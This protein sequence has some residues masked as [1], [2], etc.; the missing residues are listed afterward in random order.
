[1]I[2]DNKDIFKS[3]TPFAF[4]FL[5]EQLCYVQSYSLSLS[6]RGEASKLKL[7]IP[8]DSIDSSVFANSE[9]EGNK[10]PVELY[11]GYLKDDVHQTISRAKAQELAVAIKQGRSDE[12]KMF[13][14]RF[15]GFASQ[16]EWSFGDERYLDLTCFDW[17]QVLREYKFDKNLKDGDTE[18][19]RIISAIQ[20]KISGIAINSKPYNGLQRMGEKD[21]ESGSYTYRSSGKTYW[22]ILSECAAKLNRRVFV[23]GQEILVDRF[24]N[25]PVLWSMYYGPYEEKVGLKFGQYFKSLKLRYG[26][27]GEASKSNV[28][29]QLYSSVTT[30]KG[31]KSK[32]TAVRYPENAPIKTNTLVIKRN[33]AINTS[34]AELK[35]IAE[36]LFK[37]FSRKN[38]TGNIDIPFANNFLNL[39]DLVTFTA[40]S[41]YTDLQFIK[42]FYFCVNSIDENYDVSGYTQTVDIDTDPDIS[43]KTVTIEDKLAPKPKP[44]ETKRKR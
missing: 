37:K 8:L 19:S 35:V 20:K 15:S 25:K 44:K 40:D 30:K 32:P 18:V 11:V 17:S 29:I 31:N 26:E 24:K 22:Q 5:G 36:N 34:E 39:L 28:V 43:E 2:K 33:V 12:Q 38:M 14:K 10:V 41:E 27:I 4:V 42:G 16:P 1:M 7:K 21:A 23:T 6:T 3:H 13:S 9:S